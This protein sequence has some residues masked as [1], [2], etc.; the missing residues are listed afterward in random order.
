MAGI[1]CDQGIDALD[2]LLA[3]AMIADSWLVALFTNNHTPALNSL[4]GDFTEASFGGYGRE[5]LAGPTNIGVSG[6]IALERFNSV[7][8]VPT[9]AGL[10]VTV[11]GYMIV[12]G[13]VLAGAELFAV[14]IT[15][16]TAGLGINVLPSLTYQDRSV[17]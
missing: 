2:A 10:P 8:F 17:A 6:N 9:G 16:T 15:L 12:K 4:I 7:T 1:L 14:P 11:Y 3:A 13:A 5:A